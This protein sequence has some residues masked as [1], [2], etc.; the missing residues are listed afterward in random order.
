MIKLTLVLFVALLSGCASFKGN[1]ENRIVCTLAK[2]KG[3]IVSLYGPIG[4]S[5]EIAGRDSAVACSVGN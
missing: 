5:S 3:Y 1:F 2:D 4:I